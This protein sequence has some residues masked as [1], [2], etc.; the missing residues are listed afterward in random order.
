MK[1]GVL[2]VIACPECGSSLQLQ[3]FSEDKPSQEVIS[4]VLK[5]PCDAWYPIIL[6]VPRLLP[7]ELRYS[8]IEYYPQFFKKF[9]GSL[10]ALLNTERS[11]L[12]Q[13]QEVKGKE[14]TI[15]RFSYEWNEFKDYNDD[16]FSTGIGPISDDFLVGK[17][18]LD[19]GCGAGR[20]AREALRRGAHEVFAM[21]LSNSVDAAF[22]NTRG[23][24]A[25][26]VIQGDIFHPPFKRM[27]FDLIY[28]L[29]ALPHTHD[30]RL[31]FHSI[32]PYLK[33]G[34]S[35]VVY[36]YSNRRWLSY[37]ILAFMRRMT[38]KLPNSLVRSLAF[39]IGLTDFVFLIQPYK[40]LN[41]LEPLRKLLQAI[42]P[43][44]IKLY[45]PRSFKTCYTDWMDRLFY[46]YVHYHSRE[47][48]NDWLKEAFLSEQSILVLENYGLIAR[49]TRPA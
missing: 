44:H 1:Q 26:H 47:E 15:Y 7:T 16:N 29:W 43:S 41:R 5:C 37:K 39:V 2:D 32:V 3:V 6:G 42:T 33:Q 35:I 48:V 28:S 31:A 12:I 34:G 25:I 21:D 38:T 18:I 14:E 13:V 23:D 9:E 20:H 46:P 22:A 27:S 10:P 49:G 40:V 45:A 19:A 4:G 11:Q 17:R 8:L 30:P 24:R 36:L